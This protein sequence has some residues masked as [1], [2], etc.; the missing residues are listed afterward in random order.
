VERFFSDSDYLFRRVEVGSPPYYNIAYIPLGRLA[1]GL[2]GSLLGLERTLLLMSALAIG[3][4]VALSL[5]LL[6]KLGVGPLVT[7]VVGVLLG[8]SPGA[9]FFGGAIEVHAVQFFGASLGI[10]LAWAA[11]T[12]RSRWAWLLLTCA[13]GVAMVS[14]L[15]NLLLLFG[16]CALAWGKRAS[17]SGVPSDDRGCRL[18]KRELPAVAA[19]LV[20]ALIA[21]SI[22]ST[23]DFEVWS[24]HP[25]LQWLGTLIVFGEIYLVELF[26]RG[27]YSPAEVLGYLRAELLAPLGFLALGLPCGLWIGLV[28]KAKASAAAQGT[29]DQATH[30][31]PAIFA[32]RGLLACVPALLVLPQGGVLERGGY[33]MSYAPLFAI[34]LGLGLERALRTRSLAGRGRR[35]GALFLLVCVGLQIT[36]AFTNRAS[37]RAQ[38]PDARIWAAAAK[39]VLREGDSLLVSTLARN[40]AVANASPQTHVRDLQRDLDMVPDSERIHELRKVLAQRLGDKRFSGDLWLDAGLLPGLTAE[41][42]ATPSGA[43]DFSAS[44]RGELYG[45]L[46]SGLP[47]PVSMVPLDFETWRGEPGL[48]GFAMD[49]APALIRVQRRP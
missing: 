34:L 16:L 9:L 43:G 35:L 5:R 3:G 15:S 19:V 37:F 25:A 26:Q 20:V 11:R 6:Q 10:S 32:R 13:L 31:A 44:W 46:T 23:C 7:L 30:S 40:F 38:V 8:L 1:N 12:R 22:L 33:F 45:Y 27:L 49:A 36:W 29:A 47:V 41:D 2:V 28:R 4:G 39:N 18:G 48:D 24:K 14:H 21:A 42:L 17:D